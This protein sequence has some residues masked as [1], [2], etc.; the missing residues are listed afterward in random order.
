[1][2]THQNSFRRNTV[3]VSERGQSI[4]EYG[5]ILVMIALSAIIILTLFGTEIG[6]VFSK[7]VGNNGEEPNPGYVVVDVVNE[8]EMGIPNVRIYAFYASGRYTGKTGRTDQN[9]R[10]VFE[11]L[12]DEV[13][14]FRANYRRSQYWSNEISWSDEW[15]AIV[16]TEEQPFTVTV[17]DQ[18]G[19][20]IDNVRVY[21]F[22]SDNRYISL[23][24]N[25]N[26]EGQ[27]IF[28]LP[29]GSYRFRADYRRHQYWSPVA[30][31]PESNSVMLNTGQRPFIV[32]VLDQ[33]GTGIENVRV[34]TFN[35][36]DQYVGLYANTDSNGAITFDLPDG[37][38]KFRADYRTHRYWSDTRTTPDSSS[39]AVHTGQ[40]PFTVNVV[41]FDG[42]GI[43]GVRVY[44]FSESERYTGV[45]TNSDDNGAAT[46]DLP[47][48]NYKFR[49]DYRSNRYWSEV[50]NIPTT[51]STT[52]QTG[53]RPFTINVLD[54]NGQGISGV[55]VYAFNENDRYSGLYVN[56][57][58][59]GQGVFELPDGR[60]KFRADYRS[61]RYWSAAISSPD[62]ASTTIQTG[63][64]S[65][66][67][68]TVNGQGAAMTNIRVYVFTD[69]NRYIGVYART[70]ASGIATLSIPDGTFKIR[71]DYQRTRYWSSTFVTG[72][73][74]EV[75]VTIQP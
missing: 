8:Q 56:T 19:T 72:N 63:Q 41:N 60:F 37:S 11:E 12:P 53:Q 14:K 68:R 70:D 54:A 51:N 17:V 52:L 2:K 13:Y 5:L 23:Y 6:N 55:R 50:A 1:M 4:V 27:L 59:N 21:A 65:I 64:K 62:T 10:L 75:T 48:G 35:A 69:S 44:A 15:H 26:E 40:Q 30:A 25:T 47:E 57:D 71:A 34:Y 32:N 22:N 28:N 46:F 61:N 20:G 43:S 18:A 24:G 38:Y 31:A 39:A 73:T 42:Q 3:A 49:A 58:A 66:L 74:S 33:A 29:A 36:S 9:G 7:I 16:Q 67:V 45:Y